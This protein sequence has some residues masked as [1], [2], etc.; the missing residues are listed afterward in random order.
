VN[1]SVVFT[2]LRQC[3][4][5]PLSNT[6]FFG[7]TRIHIPNGISVGSAIFAQLK[8]DNPY[9]LRAMG[10]PFPLKIAPCTGDLNPRLIHGFFGLTRVVYDPIDRISV[11]SAVFAE[12]V[13][14]TD[15]PTD[16]GTRFV[17][18]GRI[19]VRCPVM[20]PNKCT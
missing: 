18:K 14:V 1:G 12:L 16:H 4:R 5:E 6:W 13:I 9:P 15:R 20:Q 8:T 7:P 19:Y 10:R 3:E 11:G 2:R 17:T